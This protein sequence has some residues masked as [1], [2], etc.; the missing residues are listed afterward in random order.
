MQIKNLSILTLGDHGKNKRV[1]IANRNIIQSGFRVGESIHVD[2]AKDCKQI[3][4]TPA[5][6][7]DNTVSGR[8][9]N[10]PIIDLKNGTVSEVLGQPEKIEVRFYERRIV[11]SVAKCEQHKT[12]R[13]SKTGMRMFEIFAG[14][15]TLHH[16]FKQAGYISAGGLEMN[17]NYLTVFDMNNPE[18]DTITLCAAIEDVD[19]SDY[20]ENI[21]LV[22]AGYPCTTW[23]QGNLKMAEELKKLKNGESAD[24]KIVAQ[25]H[26]AEALVYHLLRAIEKMAPRQ[27]VIEEVPQFADSP[28][29][30]IL[31]TVLS[32][33]GFHISETVSE[34]LHTKRKR[35]CLTADM[36]A[37]VDLSNLPKM[38]G[39]CLGDLVDVENREWVSVEQSK[40]FTKA[41]QTIGLRSHL[42]G[43]QKANTFTTHSTRS[44]EPCLKHPTQPLYSE[45]S[46]EEIATIHGLQGFKLP[47]VKSLARQILGQGVAD[48]FAEIARRMA[49]NAQAVCAPSVES[50]GQMIL[51]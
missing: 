23:S 4:I 39:K 42:P 31:R 28:A 40:R 50:K 33:W 21:D 49:V 51:F 29:S 16:F 46:N 2:Y 38:D 34:A 22:L 6:M 10:A 7:G 25:R 12:R 9:E 43:E 36:N 32:Q 37:P 48:M 11:I 27:V 14:G 45:F 26:S 19:P 1:W 47:S 17:D 5:S 24:P 41:N 18:R 3:E 13:Q 20:P 44:T 30:L 15:G 8:N 35:W